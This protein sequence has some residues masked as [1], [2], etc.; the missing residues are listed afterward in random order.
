VGVVAHG[1]VFYGT[2]QAATF[3]ECRFD[4]NVAEGAGGAL[5]GDRLTVESSV[6]RGNRANFGGAVSADGPHPVTLSDCLIIENH[7][8]WGGGVATA[9]SNL[10]IRR[11]TIAQNSGGGGVRVFDAVATLESTIV[12]FN[13]GGS[14]VYCVPPNASAT[15]TCSDAYG[16]EMGDWVGC[17]E[18]AAGVDGNFSGDPRFCDP[19]GGDFHLMTGSPCLPENS[20]AC[21]LIG[22]FGQGC[23]VVSV[24]ARSW[25]EIKAAY[26]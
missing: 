20:G 9:R 15:A 11:C 17:L 6:F 3:L 5:R 23:G 1:G 13:T 16:N 10:L 22:A 25:G 4:D 12:A 21:G 7:A 14:A 2:L 24:E 18:T 26:R 19:V 8:P